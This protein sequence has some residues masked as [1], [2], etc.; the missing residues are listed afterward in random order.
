MEMIRRRRKIPETL[1][2]VERRL[3]IS[4]PGTMRR[5]FEKNAQRQKWV[6]R[7]NKKRRKEIGE[8]DGELLTRATESGAGYQPI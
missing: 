5:N 2:L 1:R 3:E 8:I 6:P 4:R 7:P